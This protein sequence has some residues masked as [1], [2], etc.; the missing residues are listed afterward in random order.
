MAFPLHLRVPHW[1]KEAVVKVNDREWG[2]AAASSIIKVYRE[3]TS[4]DVVELE[5]PMGIKV[6]RWYERSA[7]I[8]RGPLVYALKVGENWKKVQD[9]RKFGKHYQAETLPLEDIVLVP[10]GCTT[11]R[12]T[13][14]PV[15]RK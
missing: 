10:Y 7:V 9:D 12:I 4:D 5:M 11:L 2:K 1:C 3:W 14:F 6:S 8:E 15:T 13:E